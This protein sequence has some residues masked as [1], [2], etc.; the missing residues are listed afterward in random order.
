MSARSLNWLK[1]GGLVGLAFG[2][3]LLFAGLLDLPRNSSAQQP[4]APGNGQAATKAINTPTQAPAIPGTASLQNL[5]DDF[6]AVAEAVLLGRHSIFD[7]QGNTC[8]VAELAR[9][10]IRGYDDPRARR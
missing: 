8:S 9:R 6:A 1:F 7:R 10:P 3:G 2:L 5:S 4:V